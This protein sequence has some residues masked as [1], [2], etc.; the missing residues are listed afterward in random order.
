MNQPSGAAAPEVVVPQ[1]AGATPQ[2]VTGGRGAILVAAG[3]FLSRIVGL[4]RQRVFAHY[5]G[6]SIAAAAFA[7]A[8][9]IPNYLQNLLG[10]GV[11]SAS[12]IPVYA[13]L[14]GKGDRETADRV[15]GAVFGLLALMTSALVALGIAIA[16]WLVTVLAPGLE[17]EGRILT[18]TLVRILFPGTGLLVFSAWCLGILNSHRKFFLSYAAP[19]VWNVAIIAVLV[20]FGGRAELFALAEYTAWGV[21]AG[22]FLQ[23]AVQLPQVFRLLGSFRPSLSAALAPVRQV[24]K[25]FVPVVIGRGVVQVSAYVDLAFASLITERAISALAYAQ[26]I[27]LVPVSL[28]GMAVSAAELPEL[29]R[30]S[31]ASEKLRERLSAGLG[32]IAFFV[33][34]SA[35]AFLFLGDVVGAALL[36]T[37]RF[38]AADTR[39]VWFILMGSAVGLLAATQGRLYASAFYAL[40]DTRTPLYFA[41]ARVGLGAGLVFYAVRFLPA[42]LGV[43]VEL[44]AAGITVASGVAGWVEYGLLRRA[45]ARRIGAVKLPSGRLVKLWLA[46]M[47][48]A[49]IGVGV[50]V[51]LTHVFG[52]DAAVASQW[53]SSF[54]PPPR[55]HPVLS[56]FLVLGAFGVTYFAVAQALG[57]SLWRRGSRRPSP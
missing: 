34:P 16:P 8:L 39:Y 3:I 55:L 9:R 46:A 54:L 19:V 53:G 57:V 2:A 29:A 38:T 7:A 42:Q 52:V 12:F 28:F 36:Q 47:S 50:K 17:G 48:A 56:A 31:E 37:G 14:T 20:V 25:S 45:L 13:A 41:L 6:N 26:T 1:P 30:E 43:P 49:A 11:L 27:Y 33:V 51:S 40:R 15:A 18:I 24:L 21:V 32:R 10:E 22:S 44:G 35:A 23:F 4:L 5:F